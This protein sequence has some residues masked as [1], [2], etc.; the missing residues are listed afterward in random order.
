MKAARAGHLCTVQFLISKGK[1]S[2]SDYFQ[3]ATISGGKKSY[4]LLQFMLKILCLQHK[5]YILVLCCYILF[6]NHRVCELLIGIFIIIEFEVFIKTNSRWLL[7]KIGKAKCKCPGIF[8]RHGT[9]LNDYKAVL[10]E[11]RGSRRGKV[12]YC[13]LWDS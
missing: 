3:E 1:E 8:S 11:I 6:S 7:P 10:L 4:K 9:A 2:T 12:C 5:Y 13:C